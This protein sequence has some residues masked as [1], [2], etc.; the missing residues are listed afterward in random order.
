MSC[1]Q[2]ACHCHLL[3]RQQVASQNFTKFYFLNIFTYLPDETFLLLT[4]G[5]TRNSWIISNQIFYITNQI[6]LCFK[7]RIVLNHVLN[8][9]FI[10]YLILSCFILINLLYFIIRLVTCMWCIKFIRL[11]TVLLDNIACPRM[12]YLRTIYVSLWVVLPYVT[13][14]IIH[15]HFQA[16]NIRFIPGV[17]TDYHFARLATPFGW[18]KLWNKKVK[19]RDTS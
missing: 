19:I 15:T 3:L 9:K 2:Y 11:A 17:E 14:F 5:R 1:C 13:W 12:L 7:L 10:M 8:Q 18:I 16:N 6:I 4:G